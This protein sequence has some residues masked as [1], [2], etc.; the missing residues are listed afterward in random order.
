MKK[1]FVAMLILLLAIK[2]EALPVSY[3][4]RN[5]NRV[6]SVKNQGI[7]GPCW[8]FAAVSAMESN[9]VT[10]KLNTDGKSPDLS[11]IKDLIIK[12]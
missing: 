2:S 9:Y 6:T 10:Q 5:Y 3:D 1:F 12:I 8:A 4:L 11:I 7:P